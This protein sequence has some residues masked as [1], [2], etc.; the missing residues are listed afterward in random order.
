ML[1]PEFLA[2]CRGWP[3]ITNHKGRN[4]DFEN[5]SIEKI[6]FTV[7][8]ISGGLRNSFDMI[9]EKLQNCNLA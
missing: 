9:L 1:E 8:P 3:P 5:P 4:N 2:G 7:F 6:D